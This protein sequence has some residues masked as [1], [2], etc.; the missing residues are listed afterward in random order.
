MVRPREFDTQTAV[1][2]ALCV[3]RKQGYKGSSLHDL[4]R[5]MSISK[6]SFYETFGSKYEL[7]LATLTR[8]H[9][10]EAVYHFTDLKNDIPA[11]TMIA[12]MF[13]QLIDS[14]ING[15]GGCM[16]GNSAVEFSGTDPEVTAQI[17]NGIKQLE[18][19]FY[20]IL[21]REQKNGEILS[22]KHNIR[23]TARQLTATFYGLQ[24]MANANLNRE[25][26]N[27]IASNAVAMLD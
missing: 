16:F 15:K 17:A 14:V 25:M 3:F 22:V 13:R 26:L 5:A 1:D 19:V 23:T 24:I 12:G 21:M 2:Q 20:Q 9:E 4:I 8:F 27:D 10:T 7:F 18:Q 6:S 11:K